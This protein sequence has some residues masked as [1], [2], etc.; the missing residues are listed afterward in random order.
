MR[1]KEQVNELLLHTLAPFIR[2]LEKLPSDAVV[3]L[4]RVDASP[5]LHEAIVFYSAWPDS[6]RPEISSALETAAGYLRT[7]VA[8][9]I[10]LHRTPRFIFRRDD[11]IDVREQ[12]DHVL[13]AIH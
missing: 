9:R 1:R 4:T 2:G 10:T 13:D 7:E 12:T 3:T 8:R 11:E 6:Y 5:D